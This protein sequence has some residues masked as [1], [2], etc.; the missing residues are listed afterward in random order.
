MEVTELEGAILGIVAGRQPCSAYAVRRRF[1]RSPTWGWSSSKGG[2]YPA[3]KRLLSRNFLTAT[4]SREGQRSAQLELSEEGRRALT[5]WIESISSEMACAP[6]DPIR[7]R[8]NYL[9]AVP[10]DRRRKF[11]DRASREVAAALEAASVMQTDDHAKDGWSLAAG[12]L[13]LRMQLEA[14]LSWLRLL[15]ADGVGEEGGSAD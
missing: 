12:R 7:T 8:V 4:P 1:E 14:K 10:R 11:L 6:V 3:I 5:R 13:G 2:I 15:L 9:F